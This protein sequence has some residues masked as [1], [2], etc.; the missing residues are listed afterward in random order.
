M[1]VDRNWAVFIRTIKGQA[2]LRRLKV[3]FYSGTRISDNKR[4]FGLLK[5]RCLFMWTEVRTA[6]PTKD[7]GCF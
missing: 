4:V 2:M 3:V 6:N 5:L 7:E 1:L